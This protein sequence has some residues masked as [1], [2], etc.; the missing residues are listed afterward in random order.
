MCSSARIELMTGPTEVIAGR[1][2]KA[3]KIMPAISQNDWIF[4]FCGCGKAVT[5]FF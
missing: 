3:I 5:P 2:L 1:K 4:L